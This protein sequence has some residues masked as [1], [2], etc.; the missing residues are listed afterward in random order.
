MKILI[1]SDWYSPSVNGV[2][3]SVLNLVDVLQKMNHDVRVLTLSKSNKSHIDDHVYYI[4]SVDIKVYP[5]VR[6]T[7]PITSGAIQKLV[8]WEPDIIHS[9]CEF[10][11]YSF[12]LHISNMT[13]A[14]IVHTYHTMYEHYVRYLL[15]SERLSTKWVSPMMRMRLKRAKAIIVPTSKVRRSLEAA[16]MDTPLYTI[17]TGLDLSAFDRILTPEEKLALRDRYNIPHDVKI[18]GNLGRIG[19]EKNVDELVDNFLL[20]RETHPKTVLL[21]VGFG[22]Y[23]ETLQ[24]RIEALGASEHII[25]TGKVKPSEVSQYYQLFDVFVS[26]S[27]SE[28]QGLTYIEALASGTCEVSREDD[29]LVDV[30]IEGFNGYTYRTQEEFLEYTRKILD[31]EA[32]QRELSK[33][34][35]ETRDRFSKENFGKAVYDVYK[36]VLE[37]DVEPKRLITRVYRMTKPIRTTFKVIQK[38][39]LINSK[40]VLKTIGIP[41]DVDEKEEEVSK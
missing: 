9:Q 10:F 11:T 33:N 24:A 36:K 6:G 14:P 21:M 23:I 25:F 28:T 1:T 3:T 4:R 34:A 39:T 29:C 17:P 2:V 22:P 5:D 27:Q 40:K 41:V 16:D 26:A 15:K 35:R 20:L 38:D 8:D 30:I 12:A 7:I 32:F 37:E 31:D 13:G 19:K 18:L